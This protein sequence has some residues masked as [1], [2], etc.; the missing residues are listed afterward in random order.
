MAS[1]TLGRS[2]LVGAILGG[3]P[4][5]KKAP[6]K[7]DLG[8]VPPPPCLWKTPTVRGTPPVIAKVPSFE[9]EY[10]G[11]DPASTLMN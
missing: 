2:A 5:P 3:V 9:L 1:Q 7:P 11:L 6:Y 8:S 10:R 4:K